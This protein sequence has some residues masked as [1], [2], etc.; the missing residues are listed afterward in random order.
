MGQRITELESIIEQAVRG[1]PFMKAHSDTISPMKYKFENR[2][3]YVGT[4]F[5]SQ[6]EAQTFVLFKMSEAGKFEVILTSPPTQL[7]LSGED[8]GT[9]ESTTNLDEAFN[10]I[11]GF[12]EFCLKVK[13]DSSL[14]NPIR[15]LIMEVYNLTNKYEA[16]IE[17][18][19][20]ET[21][22]NLKTT[23]EV[24]RCLCG[25]S[26]NKAIYSMAACPTDKLKRYK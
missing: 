1:L 6:N 14:L 2:L 15:D 9:L 23:N 12:N 24:F 11:S 16:A 4:G 17:K 22:A 25:Y 7:I 3:N 20:L 21:I 19:K 8:D 26:S 10:F 13:K 18:T 5:C